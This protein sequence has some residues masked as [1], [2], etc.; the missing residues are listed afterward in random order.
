MPLPP[1]LEPPRKPPEC[2]VPGDRMIGLAAAMPP[3][4]VARAIVGT[5]RSD[6]LLP[7][8]QFR[9]QEDDDCDALAGHCAVASEAFYWLVGGAPAGYTPMHVRHEGASHWWIRGPHGE[10]W[11]L[12]ARQFRTPVP[13]DQSRG[14]GFQGRRVP[15]TAYQRPSARACVAM[16]RALGAL[17]KLGPR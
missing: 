13:Y 14:T 5:L 7:A 2:P 3:R 15:G 10:T 12:T 8:W 1:F 16:Y 6:L 4:D 17:A 11:D 9:H